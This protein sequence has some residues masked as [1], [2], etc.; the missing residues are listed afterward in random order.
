[1]TLSDGRVLLEE[2]VAEAH[3]RSP[4]WPPVQGLSQGLRRSREG[5]FIRS[6]IERAEM[7]ITFGTP[8]ARKDLPLSGCPT[9]PLGSA[10]TSAALR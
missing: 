3:R 7:R 2:D 8:P 9:G 5:G 6:R 10:S 1:M 4:L